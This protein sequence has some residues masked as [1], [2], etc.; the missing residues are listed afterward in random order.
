MTQCYSLT[1]LLKWAAV[2]TIP[3]LDGDECLPYVQKDGLFYYYAKSEIGLYRL[4]MTSSRDLQE[5]Q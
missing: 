1:T 3:Y 5:P 4:V 2:D